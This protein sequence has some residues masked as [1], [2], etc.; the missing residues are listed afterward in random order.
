M[1]VKNRKLSSKNENQVNNKKQQQQ[2]DKNRSKQ[3]GETDLNFKIS[4]KWIF[5][6]FLMARLCSSLWNNINDCD[7]TFNYWE[8]GHFLLYGSGFQTWEYSPKYSIRSYTYLWFYMLPGKLFK[9]YFEKFEIFYIIRCY[10]AILSAIV[11][12]FLFIS[13][14]KSFG[15]KN[16][17]YYCLIS[18]LST[19]MF[20]SMTSFLPSSFAIYT[21]CLS[22]G[23]WLRGNHTFFIVFFAAGSILGW[24]FVSAIG[25]PIALF[26][27]FSN[28]YRMKFIKISIISA[29]IISL[30]IIIIDTYYYGKFVFAPINIIL[31]NVFSEHGS[32]LYGTE[33]FSFYLKNLFLNF[34]IFFIIS[35]LSIPVLIISSLINNRMD[36]QNLQRQILINFSLLVWYLIFF[37][38][39]HK[40]ERFMYPI[41]PLL[42]LTTSLTLTNLE[43]IINN[44]RLQS[45]LIKLLFSIFFLL[46]LSRTL[47]LYRGYYSSLNIYHEFWRP[48]L[49]DVN[50]DSNQT[51]TTKIICLGKEWHRFPSNFFIPEKK[52]QIEFIRS[53]FR[54]QLPKYF[55]KKVKY[56]TR[57]EPN[58]MNDQNQ[59]QPERYVNDI[60][61][62]CDYI[63]DSDYPD[64]YGRDYPYSKHP[65]SWKIIKS[66]RYLNQKQSSIVFR[67]FYLP[68][69]FEYKCHFIDYNILINAR[70]HSK[71]N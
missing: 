64:F 54:G 32:T 68:F 42:C 57:I 11:E 29:I 37:C 40:E 60:Q 50:N 26:Y 56:P 34:N 18:S 69:L 47:A 58:D 24:P 21:V 5:I 51:S 70:K 27:L 19:G 14:R 49:L 55:D 15:N 4:S 20:N 12:T 63:I 35:S 41:Y 23:F 16:A 71:S 61:S 2:Q 8:P 66:F 33:P 45:I 17:L 62:D 38:Q 7:E 1:P 39:S 67:T 31:Y 3:Q 48:P 28:R 52:F 59:E 65:E 22:F 44:N 9:N 30:P 53:E 13:I 36:R 25:I 6:W 46:S 43:S 10:M